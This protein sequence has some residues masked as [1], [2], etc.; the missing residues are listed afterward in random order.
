MR[1]ALTALILPEAAHAR[2]AC[3][4]GSG[5]SPFVNVWNLVPTPEKLPSCGQTY[6]KP[7]ILYAVL[8]AGT[9]L[10]RQ[11]HDMPA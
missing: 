10:R 3:V 6:E 1:A 2:M 8:T 7:A 4:W 9:F 5:S 11:R